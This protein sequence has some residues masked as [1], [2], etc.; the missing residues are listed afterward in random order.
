[1]IRF[2]FGLFETNELQHDT[3]FDTGRDRHT[4]IQKIDEKSANMN[5][6]NTI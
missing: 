1:M 2:S 5:Y 3:H 4:H 6:K